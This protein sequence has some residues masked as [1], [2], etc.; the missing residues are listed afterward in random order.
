MLYKLHFFPRASN[1]PCG[2]EKSCVV[3]LLFFLVFASLILP[4]HRWI[5]FSFC[6]CLFLWAWSAIIGA[7]WNDKA[8][9]N[10][11]PRRSSCRPTHLFCGSGEQRCCVLLLEATEI[12]RFNNF[13]I[14][15]LQLAKDDW[16]LNRRIYILDHERNTLLNDLQNSRSFF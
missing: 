6:F 14:S 15:E 12:K 11:L 10:L 9:L 8:E 7:Y 1:S 13:G 5:L 4:F 3:A 16:I 2:R